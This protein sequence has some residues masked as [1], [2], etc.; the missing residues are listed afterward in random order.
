MGDAVAAI[1]VNQSHRGIA[2]AAAAGN[3]PAT[4]CACALDQTHQ[5]CQRYVVRRI[6]VRPCDTCG[7]TAQ[8]DTATP[9]E[10]YEH[11]V[12]PLWPKM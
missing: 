5:S 9:L 2:A 7:V 11:D 4:V 1:A 12:T 3:I 8:Y 6:C 10:W